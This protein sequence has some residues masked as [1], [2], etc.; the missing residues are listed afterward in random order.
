MF[1]FGCLCASVFYYVLVC[2]VCVVVDAFVEW[3]LRR[4]LVV[5]TLL[6]LCCWLVCVGFALSLLLLF[7]FVVVVVVVLCVVVVLVCFCGFMAW[8]FVIVSGCVVHFC[9]CWLFKCVVGVRLV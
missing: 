6:F 2:C 7:V 5:L 8:L 9:C 4:S 1:V 3:G